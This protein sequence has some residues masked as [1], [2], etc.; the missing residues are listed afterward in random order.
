MLQSKGF[1]RYDFHNVKFQLFANSWIDNRVSYA[2]CL[3]FQA[4]S[5][6]YADSYYG[7]AVAAYGQHAIVSDLYASSL[8]FH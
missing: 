2:R 7:G 5:Y 1:D 6:P 4:I 3:H 8:F